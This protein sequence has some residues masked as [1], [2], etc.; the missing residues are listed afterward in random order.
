MASKWLKKIAVLL[1]VGIA[2]GA[3]GCSGGEE[4]GETAQTVEGTGEAS[5]NETEDTAERVGYIFHGDAQ[6]GG[7]SEELNNQRILA[8]KYGG[9]E[10]MYIDN[11]TIS[12]F[13]QAVQTLVD[14]GC[15]YIVAG[16]SVYTNVLS[17]TAGKYMDIDFIGYGTR[18]RSAN[19]YGYVEQSFQGAYI[20]GMA[21]AYNSES[22]KIG[23]VA[24]EDM[25]FSTAVVNAAALGVQL[26]YS[27]G[28]VYAA[29]GTTDDEVTQAIDA[30]TDEGC[31]VIICYTE[32]GAAADYCEQMGI[33]FIGSLDYRDTAEDYENMLMYFCCRRDSFFLSQYKLITTG[34]WSSDTFAANMSNGVVVV[35]DALPAAKDGTSE[36]IAALAPRVTSGQAYIFSGEL[37]D[38]NDS[39][40]YMAGEYM[41]PVE[42]YTMSWYVKGASSLGSFRQPLDTLE[43]NSFEI[44]Y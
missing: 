16:S 42:I 1:A 26:V 19:V 4:S 7:F 33:S 28:E 11:V 15:S 27:N 29:Y 21:A 40:K 12:D 18:V 22:E 31:D 14:A 23:V 44:K 32:S 37:K 38:N 20:A 13:E 39:I 34:E 8:D 9:V 10:T 2:V 17:S 5:A 41:E 30:L 24:D 3:A 36:I 43:T 25:I 35:S 6:G